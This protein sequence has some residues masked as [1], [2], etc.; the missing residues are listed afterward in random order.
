MVNV[1]RKIF[2]YGHYKQKMDLVR[3]MEVEYKK[4]FSNLSRGYLITPSFARNFIKTVSE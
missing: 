2:D 4:D 3:Y 1:L